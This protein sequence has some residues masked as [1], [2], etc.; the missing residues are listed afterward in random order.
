MSELPWVHM[1]HRVT[2]S[3]TA[4]FSSVLPDAST[5]IIGASATTRQIP[6]GAP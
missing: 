5:S 3:D 2:P 6:D 1:R 4:G